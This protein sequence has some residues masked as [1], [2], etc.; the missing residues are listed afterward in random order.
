MISGTAQASADSI[1]AVL[2]SPSTCT[3]ATPT[4][5]SE[6]LLPSKPIVQDG[7]PKS[8][9]SA[10]TA[11]SKATKPPPTKS[12]SRKCGEDGDA[13][14]LS[15][16]EAY[17]L[18]TEV[19]NATLKYLGD[20]LKAPLQVSARRQASSKDL[21]KAA[22]RQTLRR[23]NSLPQSPLQPRSLNRVISSPDIRHRRSSSVA[24]NT[25]LTHR[26]MAECAR[27]GF[28]AL[29]ALQ[30]SRRSGMDLPSLQLESGMSALIGKLASL[31]LDELALKELRILKRRLE[32]SESVK[33]LKGTKA[34]FT[35]NLPVPTLAGLLDFSDV[36]LTGAKLGIAIT[37][38]MQILQLM[39]SGRKPKQV[40]ESLP[41]LKLDHQSS[42]IRLLM[43]ATE[44]C[45]TP[46]QKE[47]YARLLERLSGLLL[48]LCPSLSSSDDALALEAR[49][50]VKPEVA[51]QIQSLALHS[52]F[53]W[54]GIAGH[55]GDLSKDI[56]EPL[57][58]CLST[59]SRRSQ[60][61]MG[62]TY[63]IAISATSELLSLSPLTD[64]LK[65]QPLKSALA[66]IYSLLGSLARGAN[67]IQEAIKWT[68]YRRELLDDRVD[69]DAKRTA[70]NA[71]L[72]G[73]LLRNR[74]VGSECEDLFFNLLEA[75]DRPF[76]GESSEIEEL[77]DEVSATRR[78]AIG[79]LSQF[80]KSSGPE[81]SLLSDG[82][83]QMCESLIFLCPRLSLRYL[84]NAPEVKSNVKDTL[85]YE[86]RRK[87]ITPIS[88][89]SIDSTLLLVKTLAGEDQIEWD[90]VDSKLQDCLLLLDRLGPNGLDDDSG[91]M[92]H[93]TRISNLYFTQ[94]LNMQR[95]SDV[96]VGQQLRAV[97]RSIDCIRTRPEHEKRDA[98]FIMKLERMAGICKVLGRFDEVYQTLLL[99]QA[100]MVQNGILS[101]I[102]ECADSKPFDT[103]WSEND[104]SRM[105][106]RN[107]ESLLKIDMKHL[108][109]PGRGKLVEETWSQNEQAVVL[110]YQLEIL[111]KRFNESELVKAMQ[112][113][114]LSDL[115]STLR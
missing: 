62:D 101:T 95:K 64:C 104:Q 41:I 47:K 72:L 3:P 113:K 88:L 46:K 97:R 98:H 37:T 107:L 96:K 94:F 85:R 31:G 24:S 105:F 52:R 78:S 38:Q 13:N 44:G 74:S 71:T 15:P 26:P 50:S 66:G 58:R 11:K 18:A 80:R 112:T 12:K 5:L 19:V 108:D 86:Q 81:S 17:T 83:R 77:L 73:L 79:A 99:M 49:L 57:L 103:I 90:L 111:C 56:F 30:S 69:S 34:T 35:S 4:I 16:K 48:S 9:N 22:S 33:Q 87:F 60:F 42:P 8:K 21:V 65:P 53:L 51:V 32:L 76:K 75:L 89:H 10:T 114:A 6:L 45:S 54:W 7:N 25:S 27:V 68:E 39:T 82:L 102:A 84:G 23:S 110:E 2:S 100:E 93:Y 92:T 14:K 36:D 20:A 106:A 59:F 61:G 67:R 40:E 43:L 115:L 55:Q 63:N 28:A 91:S 70:L 29:R 1:R 109:P